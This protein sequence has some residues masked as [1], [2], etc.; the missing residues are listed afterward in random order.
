MPEVGEFYGSTE[1]NAALMNHCKDA[2]A[3]G[4]VG[5]M[6]PL[7]QKVSLDDHAF[8]HTL[9]KFLSFH[10]NDWYGYRSANCD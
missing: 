8:T 5:H 6:G 2:R 4:C 9:M 1:G 7:M 3:R 10:R